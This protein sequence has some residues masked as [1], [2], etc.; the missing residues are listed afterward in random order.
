MSSKS[1]GYRLRFYGFG[2][3]IGLLM[4]AVIL[5]GKK[6]SGPSGLKTE[7]LYSQTIIFDDKATCAKECLKLNDANIKSV[8]MK[9]HVNLSMSEVHAV[10]YGQ[11]FMEGNDVKETPYSFVIEDRDTTSAI[12]RINLPATRLCDCK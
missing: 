12:I 10:P 5:R 8:L 7:E 3:L 4:L 1:F 2:F 6:C 11:Y 9:C